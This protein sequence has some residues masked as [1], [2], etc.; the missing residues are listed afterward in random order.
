MIPKPARPKPPTLSSHSLAVLARLPT[1]FSAT[2]PPPWTAVIHLTSTSQLSPLS[3]L[4]KSIL[5]Q[6]AP[7]TSVI[8]LAPEGLSPDPK[9]HGP[10]V[11]LLQYPPTR[12]AAL[13]LILASS[14]VTTPHMV[15]IDAQLDVMKSSYVRTLLRASGTKEYG[16]A[17]LSAGGLV[18][19]ISSS[20]RLATCLVSD[21]SPDSLDRTAAIHAPSTPFLIQ[22]EWLTPL[23]NGLRTDLP[24]EVGIALALWTKSGIPSFGIPVPWDEGRRDFG[25]E[26][27]RRNVAGSEA[28][29]GLLFRRVKSS[30]RTGPVASETK[31]GGAEGDEI[32]QDGTV[33]ILL[34]GDDELELAHQLACGFA[35]EQDLRVYVAD[36]E[37]AAQG[38]HVFFPT[39]TSDA[40]SGGTRCHLDIHPLGTGAP[41][42]SIQLAV[43]AELRKIGKV[44]LAIY[45]GD[46][47]R[48]REFG[49]VMKWSEGQFGVRMGGKRRSRARVEQEGGL[50]AIPL[51][52]EDVVHSEWMSA[53]PMEALRHW[54][55]PKI[56][57]TV[58]TNDR[59]ASLHRLLTALQ[60]AHYFG[61]EISLSINLEQTADRLT[62]RL[63]DDF[64]WDFGTVTLRHR[65]ILGGLMP[66][67]VESWYPASNDTYGVF[68]EDDV[69][70]SPMF[71]SWLKF[72]ILQ[73]RY[74]TPMRERSSRL[75]GVSLYQ[76]RN[77]ELRPEGRQ[78]FD[79]HK[80]FFSLSMPSTLPY[81]SQ[82]P[83]SWGA[84]Y[85]PEVWREFH[86]YLAL[87][88][89]ETALPI[90]DTI[91]P[92]I[93]SNKWPRSWKKYF[94]ELVYMRGYVMLYPNYADFASFSN[95]HLEKG[96][97]IHVSAVDEKRKRQ[98]DVPLMDRNGSILDLPEGRLPPWDA[99]PVIDL[100]GALASDDDL[101]ERG[102]QSVA[103][104]DTCPPFRLD[105]PPTHNA[106][107]LL[108]AKV[109]E[110]TNV[111]VEAQPLQA[112]ASPAQGDAEAPKAAFERPALVEHPNRGAGEEV[113]EA[114]R[115]GTKPEELERLR[116]YEQRVQQRVGGGERDARG[117]LDG[118][119]DG[120][121][122]RL[123]EDDSVG[124]VADVPSGEEAA[125]IERKEE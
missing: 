10:L 49:E 104:L 118:E 40:T 124:V 73:Y 68:L 64:S 103:Q 122:V 109:Y 11:S 53:L 125:E 97:H 35:Q 26:R 77:I 30:A 59:P 13:A 47:A 56:D 111:L 115:D 99:L 36:S 19:P 46:G 67:I 9:K 69:E 28:K 45:V 74:Y 80:L 23:S 110:R 101:I 24:L 78:P 92:E 114:Q 106:R 33:V 116:A 65:I 16:S 18:L 44:E 22:T 51:L 120:S 70:V 91:V 34:S 95:N 71:Y 88:L 3:K 85:F 14:S 63:V 42:E 75:F 81:L 38:P 29:L 6:S 90:S 62:Q 93:R 4:I 112:T 25:C 121:L 32:Q 5:R 37:S 1:T 98:F 102:W 119:D 96:T 60:D 94:I 54:H 41:G 57:I 8:I 89:S 86:A 55:V 50:V 113:D 79:A 123:E 58:I 39:S 100:W 31:E 15:I 52:K 117:V 12:P 2:T 82:I 27:L 72:T 108:C 48:G 105:I 20:S 107:E 84:A 83:C 87:R 17:L 76:Q 43:I 61:D 66:A 21:G 7:P